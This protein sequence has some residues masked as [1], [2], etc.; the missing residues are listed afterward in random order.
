MDYQQIS[1]FTS[2]VDGVNMSG[3]EWK[4]CLNLELNHPW[5]SF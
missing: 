3:V 1:H 5:S 2:T 4:I